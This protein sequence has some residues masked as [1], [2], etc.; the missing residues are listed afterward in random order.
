MNDQLKLF[1]HTVIDNHAPLTLFLFHGTGG[2]KSDFLFMDQYLQGRF[3]LVG[4]SGNVDEDGMRRF[5]RRTAP[6]VF[7][8]ESIRL[9]VKKLEMFLTAFMEIHGADPDR[10]TYLGFSNGANMLVAS[11]FAYP[12]TLRNLVLLRPMLP[13]PPDRPLDL[14]GHSIFVSHGQEDLMISPG[15]QQ[16]IV[17]TFR[18]FG[19]NVVIRTYPTGHDLGNDEIRDVIAYLNTQQLLTYD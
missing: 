16:D 2:D 5:F 4:I 3:N 12:G 11:L 15:Q 18:S 9:E 1:E 17:E 7:D 8:T 13:Y 14:G 6:G 19:A 10:S